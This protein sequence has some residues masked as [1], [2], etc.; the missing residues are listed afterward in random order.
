MAEA[1][2]S[3][4]AKDKKEAEL[5]VEATPVKPAKKPAR[6]KA[7]KP[8]VVDAVEEPKVLAKAGKRSAKAVAE[9]E[10]KEVWR[11][12]APEMWKRERQ[13]ANGL[14]FFIWIYFDL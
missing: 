13:P 2:K 7:E 5:V 8:A 9:I 12:V 4:E 10:E 1:K 3:T 6:V 11:R 14:P